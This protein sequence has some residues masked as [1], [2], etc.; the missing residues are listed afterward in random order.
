MSRPGRSLRL[1]VEPTPEEAPV[2]YMLLVYGNDEVWSSFPQEQWQEIVAE[3]DRVNAEL[4]DEGVL[5]GGYGV[6]DLARVVRTDGGARVVTD[7]P[8]LETKEHLGSFYIVDVASDEEALAV[9]ARIPSSKYTGVEVR[10]L[11]HEA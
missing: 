10:P 3:H 4:M 1:T 9:A 5:L 8:Y 11:L 2:K 6:G 7:G